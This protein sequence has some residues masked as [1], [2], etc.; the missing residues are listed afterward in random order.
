MERLCVA[1]AFVLLPLSVMAAD[2]GYYARVD[3]GYSWTS[4]GVDGS[5][6]IGA[7]VGYQFTDHLR[8]DITLG[9]RGWYSDSQSTAVTGFG[10]LSGKADIE[11]TD[12]MVNA[13]YDI[14]HYNGFTPYVGGG[15]GLAYNHTESANLALNG[16]GIGSI[17]S[18]N[19]TDV[20]WQLGAGTAYAFTP[21]VSLDV[22][23]RYMDMGKAQ[24][25]DTFTA[26]NGATVGGVR[27]TAD[28][29][30][31]ELQAGLRFTF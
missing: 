29:H 31:S 4:D 12:A 21:S 26:V 14:G 6:I 25:G 5:A 2:S 24:T 7:G 8:G 3:T 27:A 17:N 10:T 9:E 28:L 15:I 22:G 16:V 23:Y 13:Y 19:R 30:G 1:I 20:A 11:S 18:D